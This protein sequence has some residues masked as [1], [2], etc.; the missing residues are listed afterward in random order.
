MWLI[1]TALRRPYTFIVMAV[2]LALGGVRAM[3][4]TPT[5]IFPPINI[6]VISV[7]WNYGGLSPDQMEKRVT[8]G[9]ERFLTT[10]VS[11]IDHVE[12]Q[13]LT[14][15]AIIKL[16]LQPDANVAQAI[17]QTTAIAQTAVRQMPPGAV[18]PLI[19]QYNATSVP[20]MMLALET[21]SL[22]EQQL[23]DYGI[24]FV[25]SELTSI[26]GAQIPY[27]Y[28]GKQ[29]QIMIDIDP[30]RLHGV[31]LSPRDVQ[32]AL[33]EQNVILPT[34]TVKLGTNEY[35]V[36]VAG[37]PETLEELSN[38]P[39]KTVEGRTIYLKDIAN[40]RDGSQ[41]QT[42]M[43]HVEGKRSVLMVVMKNGDARHRGRGE[44]GDPARARS[45]AGGSA[46]APDGEGDVRS[47]GVRAHVDQR[48]D[49]GRVDRG[50][51][52]GP[53]DLAVPRQL[54]LDADRDHDDSA[55][56]H[57]LGDRAAGARLHAQRHDARWPRARGRCARR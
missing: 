5:D 13:T 32:V 28:G 52:D 21:D 45:V 14:G 17:A 44:S 53:H 31:G 9:F 7:L 1:R 10:I 47:V 22:S 41:P 48:R 25:R 40:V 46:R 20:I 29:R 34:G 55:L 19:M 8:N 33:S 11:D 37:T 4:T 38:F 54:A 16:Y 26:P 36:L 56:D 42:N 57:V 51:V 18:P 39:V 43:V 30:R 49:Q 27:P 50:R 35:P 3:R 12:S 23:F 6:P 24:N 15:R 2:L